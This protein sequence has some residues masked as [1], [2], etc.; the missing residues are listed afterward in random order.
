[1]GPQRR[2]VTRSSDLP[3]RTMAARTALQPYRDIVQVV[4]SSAGR[5][6]PVVLVR[7][8]GYVAARGT[9]DKLETVLDY[10][11]MLVPGQA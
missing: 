11:R 9:L 8:D 4:S 6:G 10:L 2:G 1:M 5:A 3:C 7:P